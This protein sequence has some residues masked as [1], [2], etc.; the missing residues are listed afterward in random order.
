MSPRQSLLTIIATP[1]TPDV[2]GALP[3]TYHQ[4]DELI[5]A[6]SHAHGQLSGAGRWQDIDLI[7]GKRFSV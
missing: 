3:S 2:G 7:R 1:T 5:T 4:D 6:F